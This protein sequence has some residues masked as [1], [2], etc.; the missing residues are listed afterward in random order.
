MEHLG[1]KNIYLPNRLGFHYFPD[2]DHYSQKH[3]D[4]WLPVL[5]EMKIAW[6][7]LRSPITYAI[8]ENFI[9]SLSDAK[10]RVVVDFQ[11]PLTK[12]PDWSGLEL[13]LSSYGK[14]GVK[15]AILDRNANMRASWGNSRWGNAELINDYANRW[16]NFASIALDNAVLPVLGPL[17]SGGDYWDTA[18][19]KILL[20]EIA[21][22]APEV[23][24]SNMILSAYGWDYSRS[25]DWGAGG[26]VAWPDALPYKQPD[27]DNQNQ[28]GFRA[29]EWV[30]DAAWAVFG[31]PLPLIVLEAGIS[32]GLMGED[33]AS[34]DLSRCLAVLGLL[35][36]QNVY[37]TQ[38]SSCLLKP[39]PEY[40]Q[41]ACFF[42]LSSSD[43][44]DR[45]VCW[46]QE[47]GERLRSAQ[48]FYVREGLLEDKADSKDQP[49]SQLFEYKSGRYILISD[50]LAQLESRILEDLQPYLEKEKSVVGF[51][52]ED[53][54]QAAFIT[55]VSPDGA[56]DPLLSEKLRS[57]GSLVKVIGPEEIPAFFMEN[58]YETS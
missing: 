7:V 20:D 9:Q 40:V 2:F 43:P 23:I 18:F 37:D 12:E 27:Q 30:Q 13:L 57:N 11:Y 33:P 16:V 56:V 58:D 1:E 39:V 21:S 17:V 22:D 35:K 29:Y 32:N 34:S 24:R 36:D 5:R 48:A 52:I 51:S 38:N 26:S 53:A 6:I 4:Q 46:F 8:P 15:Y 41:S 3:L 31:R 45:S 42:V 50:K 47:N 28:Q 10:I 49:S 54:V 44:E 14:W 55:Y 19:L 25:L